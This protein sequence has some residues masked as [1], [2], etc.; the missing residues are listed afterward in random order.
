MT[1]PRVSF[2]HLSVALALPFVAIACK[3]ESTSTPTT[4]A[5]QPVTSVTASASHAAPPASSAPAPRPRLPHWGP[6]GQ[7]LTAAHEL[8]GLK[9]D[10]KTKIEAI[11]D[12][13]KPEPGKMPGAEFK[14]IHDDFTAGVKAGKIDT[15]KIDADWDAAQKAQQPMLDKEA[16]ALNQLH[17]LLDA[18]QRKA[19]TAAVRAKDAERDAKMAEKKDEK[20]AKDADK[21]AQAERQKR[22]VDRMTKELDLDDAQ[23]KKAQALVAKQVPA[24]GAHDDAM[25]DMQKKH[26]ALLTAFE[27]DTF[28]AKKQ[29][30][31]KVDAKKGKEP[32]EKQEKYL[33]DLLGILKPEQR[34]KLAASMEK[35][36]GR[37]GLGGPGMMGP[38]GRPGMAG[39]GGPGG[40][41]RFGHGPEFGLLFDDPPDAAPGGPGGPGGPGAP[42][43]AAPPP[44]PPGGA[45][46][47][48][49]P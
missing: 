28:D 37:G 4:T 45:P 38:H 25:K 23:Q 47:A 36:H 22:M 16:D 11:E 41:G 35:K 40:D 14:A 33:T 10:Q 46:P 19:V 20:A 34:D 17:A 9:D 48:P 6:S 42:G 5:A 15:A 44:P 26:E 21:T 2:V 31:F 39:P 29:D 27:A 43:G 24:P 3:D 13:L 49:K 7:L 30:L 1:R 8:P 32:I 12:G 18:T